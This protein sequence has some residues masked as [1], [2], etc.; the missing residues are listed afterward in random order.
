MTE[1]VFKPVLHD[2]HIHTHTKPGLL[3]TK[4]RGS[5]TGRK[6]KVEPSMGLATQISPPCMA[7]THA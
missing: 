6:G 1:P 2:T 4:I 5:G 3:T 7:G